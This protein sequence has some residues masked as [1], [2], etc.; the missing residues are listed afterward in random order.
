MRAALALARRGLGQVWP[1]PAVG[2]VVVA[3]GIPVGR[4]WTQPGGRPH[5]ETEALRRAGDR[6]RGATA[7][8]SLEPCCHHG[9][10]PPCTEAL[11]A[12][13]VARVVVAMRDPDPRVGGRGLAL[14]AEAGIEV[15]CGLL[16]ETAGGLNAGFVSRIVRGRPTV[17]L[18]FATTL[19]G[20]IATRT[21]ASRWIT[22]A[23]ARRHAHLH[24]AEHDAV[25]VGSG[26]ALADDPALTCR[27]PGLGHRS[28]VRIV[29]D[30]ALKLPERSVLVRT[31]RATP[32]W[33]LTA[34]GDEARR[35]RLAEAGV[36]VIEV[37]AG[38]D[39]HV[40]L[41]EALAALGQ[42]GLTRVLVEGGQGLAGALLKAGLVDGACWYRAASL[43]GGDGLAALPPL[44]IEGIGQLV[45]WRR[46]GIVSLGEDL[47]ET[48][49]VPT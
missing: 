20:R 13:G 9:R 26:T 37:A 28:P 7:Y 18:K 2:C 48:Y 10:T 43:A 17:T 38:P 14:L 27:L 34:G 16:A 47:L 44:G 30:G 49:A 23:A 4:G 3:D 21:G 5:A 1:N 6:A 22:G 45:R 11:I 42:R 35:R 19:D 36:E 25:M 31:A 40:D 41:D 29:V 32:T 8:V 12:A 15:E 46:T 24:R 39:G 33:C